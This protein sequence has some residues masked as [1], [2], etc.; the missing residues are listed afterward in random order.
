MALTGISDEEKVK[1]KENGKLVEKEGKSDGKNDEKKVQPPPKI[2]LQ[3]DKDAL[4]KL[5]LVVVA[6][7]HVER[8][9]FPTEDAY[10]AE[11]EVEARA[12]EVVEA[13]KKL[14]LEV[15]SQPGNQYFLT[16]LLVDQP[17]IVINLVDTLKGRDRLQTSVPAALELSNFTYTGA[18]MEGLVI[19]ND[20]N[21]TKR[22][23]VAYDIPT[24]TFQ[25]IRRSGTTI[26]EELGLPLIVKL[27]ESGGSVGI[28][29]KAVKESYKDAQKQVDDLIA[30][31][32]I[33]VIVE[34]FIDGMEITVVAFDDGQKC[35]ILMGEKV[36]R[37]KPD[38]KHSFTSIE[39]Y[40]DAK[41]YKYKKIEDDA[42]RMKIE[43]LAVRAFNGLAHK[44]YAKF[45]VRV[46]NSTNTPYFTDSN[47]NT[48]FGPDPGLPF[49]EVCKLHGISFEDILIS[50]LSKYAK[51]MK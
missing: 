10:Q 39:S 20:R 48:A 7:S 24:P 13:V 4:K 42:L 29:N 9:W 30:T 33:P 45:D 34:R 38:G 28:D 25:Y 31:Y 16:N 26:L 23:L 49:T 2:E 41:A 21:L 37:T 1:G 44:D 14:G 6:Y 43:K 32:K 5:K 22:L 27:N 46:D 50:L 12:G 19:G 36:F 35:H 47:P 11:V 51:G 40:D 18:G 8:E 15:K 3:M 17:S